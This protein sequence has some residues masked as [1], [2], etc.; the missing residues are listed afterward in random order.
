MYTHTV[1][2]NASASCVYGQQIMRKAFDY[3]GG[4]S[5]AQHTHVQS[6]SQQ[7][8]CSRKRNAM[9]VSSRLIPA[10]GNDN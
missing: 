1:Y 5:N 2:S 10:R 3:L 9:L 6:Q 4:R 8:H 7:E